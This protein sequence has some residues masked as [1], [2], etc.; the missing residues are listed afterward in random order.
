MTKLGLAA[1]MMDAGW[2]GRRRPGIVDIAAGCLYQ[3]MDRGT[4]AV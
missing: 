2:D 3:N 1:D 4:A